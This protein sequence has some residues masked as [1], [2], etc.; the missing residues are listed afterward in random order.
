MASYNFNSSQNPGTSGSLRRE[1]VIRD[2]MGGN[3]FTVEPG[4]SG[5]PQ[6]EEVI[7]DGMV[8]NPSTVNESEEILS[9]LPV[10]VLARE[11]Q[12]G[13]AF[14]FSDFGSFESE[15][16]ERLNLHSPSG[17]ELGTHATNWLR[18]VPPTGGEIPHRP[19]FSPR[20]TGG[21]MFILRRTVAVRNARNADALRARD[22]N[23]EAHS[24]YGNTGNSSR[25]PHKNKE[26]FP[27]TKQHK[28]KGRALEE[29]WERRDKRD[30]W[31]WDDNYEPRNPK[32]GSAAQQDYRKEEAAEEQ[33][34]D[35]DLKKDNV[36]IDDSWA[37]VHSLE[38]DFLICN[39]ILNRTVLV[40]LTL[41]IFEGFVADDI[42]YNMPND[43]KLRICK[44]QT[45]GKEIWFDMPLHRQ[46]FTGVYHEAWNGIF[47]EDCADW[48]PKGFRI[49]YTPYS[50]HGTYHAP[51]TI[52]K[53]FPSDEPKLPGLPPPPP[54]KIEI[55][56]PPWYVPLAPKHVVFPP[57]D[58]VKLY[59]NRVKRNFVYWGAALVTPFDFPSSSFKTLLRDATLFIKKKIAKKILD[60]KRWKDDATNFVCVHCTEAVRDTNCY[61]FDFRP[62]FDPNFGYAACVHACARTTWDYRGK[63]TISNP[64][65]F[66]YRESSLDALPD[67]E[68]YFVSDSPADYSQ[69][70]DLKE[71]LR[72][73]PGSKNWPLLQGIWDVLINGDSP[74]VPEVY[75]FESLKL[76]RTPVLDSP[77]KKPM[78]KKESDAKDLL[79]AADP[80]YEAWEPPQTTPDRRPVNF[81][82]GKV[83]HAESVKTVLVQKK[84]AFTPR[85]AYTKARARGK[86]I[87]EAVR[88]VGASDRLQ[89]GAIPNNEAAVLTIET[90][91]A[92]DLLTSRV[93]P[94]S[95][96]NNPREV[97]SRMERFVNSASHIDS[98]HREFLMQNTTLYAQ[99]LATR[100]YNRS[101]VKSGAFRKQGFREGPPPSS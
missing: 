32:H 8:G 68:A 4:T 54:K 51:K 60:D 65:R 5:P 43:F 92:M 70:G 28:G 58:K 62:A 71:M 73:K 10:F 25:N 37:T 24:K 20:R 33:L 31:D 96:L 86:G 12:G 36:L 74:N 87:F 41:E 35:E 88:A 39:W 100:Q 34:K 64:F 47:R 94:Q 55:E 80:G 67:H 11:S 6:R 89:S 66:L 3:P 21:S 45:E 53:N 16:V 26:R 17:H 57:F 101:M 61:P 85:E 75:T 76:Q 59:A 79:T 52:T 22:L 83:T 42:A 38:K 23:R 49:F 93:T 30:D 2:G 19:P 50:R 29:K 15:F 44:D 63:A 81:R 99:L 82:H 9:T 18:S 56:I 27:T 14:T 78:T 40:F 1:E 91:L 7:R 13:Q 48:H 46:C 84:G 97:A 98:D 95:V 72:T 69:I 90:N 77:Q